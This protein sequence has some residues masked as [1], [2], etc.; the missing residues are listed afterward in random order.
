M[1]PTE[2]VGEGSPAP[3]CRAG[4][5]VLLGFHGFTATPR[6]LD[7]LADVA[8]EL[9]FGVRVPL[10]PGHGARV[11]ELA[12]VRFD[13]YLA[14]G[15]SALRELLAERPNERVVVAGL[16]T[17]ALVAMRLAAEFPNAVIGLIALA[18]ALRLVAPYPAW[19]L[20]L[21][22]H[23]RRF[24]FSVPKRH[25]PDIADPE[26]RRRHLMYA[27]QPVLAA[28]EVE[29]GGRMV[30]PF[31]RKVRCPVFI[32]HGAHDHVC[33]PTNAFRLAD[34]VGTNDVELHILERSWHIV[35][36]DYDRDLLCARVRAFLQRVL[37][38]PR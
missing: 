14:C 25:G 32:A 10:F 28:A 13:D 17:G 31:L 2:L 30:T 19:P 38:A 20:R 1:T 35:T 9:G 22:S 29:R 5:P 11:A 34:L 16:S 4:S 15:R 37:S 3:T 8:S 27:V 24:D 21:L 23:V 36:E 18:N 7:P 26:A 33:P 12:V 6:E